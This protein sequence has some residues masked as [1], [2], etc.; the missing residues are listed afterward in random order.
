MSNYLRGEKPEVGNHNAAWA[1]HTGKGLLFFSKLAS[2]KTPIGVINLADITDIKKEGT[3][4]FLFHSHGQKHAFQATSISLRDS[5]VETLEALHVAAKEAAE[6][7]KS[8]ENYK[9]AHASLTKPV[10]SAAAITPKEEK[11]EDVVPSPLVAEANPTTTEVAAVSEEPKIETKE[12]KK[13]R[14]KSRS[15]SRKRQS[16]FGSF[17]IGGKKSEE[18]VPKTESK[19]EV[20]AESP[21]EA[22]VVAASEPAQIEPS[23]GVAPVVEQ[24]TSSETTEKPA[25]EVRPAAAKRHSSLFDFKSRFGGQKKAA[26]PAPAVPAKDNEEIVTSTEAPVIPAVEQSEPLATSIA[27]PATVPTETTTIGEPST[28]ASTEAKVE[29]TQ[30][31]RADKRKSSLPFGF[32]SKKEKTVDGE[33]PLSPFA[34]LRQTVKGKKSEE[35]PVDEAR[36]TSA[37]KKSEE[38]STDVVAEPKTGELKEETIA[39][40]PAANPT[41]SATA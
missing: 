33:K 1:A 31:T 26:T 19:D 37:E 3:A 11:K 2:D 15:A 13:A 29:G 30:E 24:P 5:W 14:T 32:G 7:I 28:V 21:V 6:S 41:V 23:L 16:I 22:P 4:E 17:N 10:E 38:K 34:K 27:S 9:S 39:P 18:V 36:P 20:K 25:E 12:E 35:K 40:A 8:S